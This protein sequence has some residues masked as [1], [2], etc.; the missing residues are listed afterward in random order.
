[1]ESNFGFLSIVPVLIVIA[2]VIITK[3]TMACLIIGSVIAS[4]IA[5]GIHFF[6]KWVNALYIVLSSPTYEWIVLVCGL[7]GSLVALFQASNCVARFSDI[8]YRLANT[9]KKSLIATFLLCV[10]I[11]VDDWLAIL[12]VSNAMKTVT[13]KPKAF[14]RV[15][16]LQTALKLFMYLVFIVIYLNLFKEHGVPFTIHFFVVYLFFAIFEVSM[17]LKFVKEKSGQKS[18]SVEKSN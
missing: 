13:D 17:I 8:A 15:F 16:M 9:K 1:M 7:F 6:S 10:V 11:F 3:R 4:I 2:L 14:N 12:V 5:Y 18:G